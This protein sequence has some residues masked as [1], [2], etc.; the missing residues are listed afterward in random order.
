MYIFIVKSMNVYLSDYFILTFLLCF[1]PSLAQQ[2]GGRLVAGEM[3]FLTSP[4]YPRSAAEKDR[5]YE[6]NLD[7]VWTYSGEENT[8]VGMKFLDTKIQ[9]GVGGSNESCEFDYI[10]I[11]IDSI[12][13]KRICGYSKPEDPVVG[14]GS[15]KLTFHTDGSRNYRGFKL[16]Y[17]ITIDFDP[18][19]NNKCQEG[20]CVTD[21]GI[22]ARCE[23]KAG[24]T[25]TL[26]E[27]DISECDSDPCQ[28]DGVCDDSSML[29][30]YTCTCPFEYHGINCEK[31]KTPL[32]EESPCENDG[33]CI[34]LPKFEYECE[35]KEFFTGVNC[36]EEIG[37][38]N[39]GLPNVEETQ[40]YHRGTKLE[41]SCREGF[42]M[43]GE[44]KTECTEDD[45]WSSPL[46]KCFDPKKEEKQRENEEKQ[47][48]RKKK[49]MLVVLSQGA[50][51]LC[52]TISLAVWIKLRGPWKRFNSSLE[53][54]IKKKLPIQSI[55]TVD[56]K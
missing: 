20:D 1:R 15:A 35:C 5:T 30:H 14:L 19:K 23:C 6:P 39:P 10:K 22:K 41:F 25:G 53:E 3:Q 9:V 21:D 46:P 24:Y 44:E 8:L 31:E 50:V 52:Y 2:C 55:S 40:K 36:T 18:C 27:S 34:D 54:Q 37:C 28:N 51:F 4:G 38:K 11:E 16:A 33:N 32:C 26:C 48:G 7:C 56:Q 43:E 29:D 45:E 49:F 12:D 47:R 42:E 13:E 17:K